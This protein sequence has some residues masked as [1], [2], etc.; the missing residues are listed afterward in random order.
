MPLYLYLYIPE[1]TRI[2]IDIDLMDKRFLDPEELCIKKDAYDKLSSEAKQVIN[3][4]LDCPKEFIE[5]FLG[6]KKVERMEAKDQP[7]EINLSF[8]MTKRHVRRL[9]KYFKSKWGFHHSTEYNKVL[10]ELEKFV[11]H[12]E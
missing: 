12:L 7:L 11:K 8:R 6:K 2:P 3:T 1:D 10:N 9:R 4:I 5:F